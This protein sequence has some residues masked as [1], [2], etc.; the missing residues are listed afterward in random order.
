ML[1][2]SN[3]NLLI[4]FIELNLST[5]IQCLSPQH[6]GGCSMVYITPIK[7]SPDP[8]VY[9]IFPKHSIIF[10]RS[11]RQRIESVKKGS[12]NSLKFLPQE[13]YPRNAV[14]HQDLRTRS[15]IRSPSSPFSPCHW[16]FSTNIGDYVSEGFRLLLS[17]LSGMP[18]RP[19]QPG[20][21]TI[22]ATA[23]ICYDFDGDVPVLSF[24]LNAMVELINSGFRCQV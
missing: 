10:T 24:G 11:H 9:S 13:T 6:L 12:V 23:D 17:R 3:I 21:G 14:L 18:F 2:F 7:L 20:V 19:R 8:Y 22:K 15:R 5:S 1:Y 16:S 4:T